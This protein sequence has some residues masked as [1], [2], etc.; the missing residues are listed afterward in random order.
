MF[1]S[2]GNFVKTMGEKNLASFGFFGEELY[3]TNNNNLILI[4]LYTNEKRLLSV[5][6]SCRSAL[7]TDDTLYAVSGNTVTILEFKP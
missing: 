3:Y 7:V 1:N 2:L 5:S 4:D 6:V